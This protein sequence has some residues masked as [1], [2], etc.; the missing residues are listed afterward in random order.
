LVSRPA[1]QQECGAALFMFFVWVE[2]FETAI[3]KSL[4]LAQGLKSIFEN[5]VMKSTIF[6]LLFVFSAIIGKAQNSNAVFFTEQGERFSVVLNGV[7][8]NLEPATNIKLVDLHAPNYRLKIIFENR[9][10]G[11]FDRNLFLEPFAENTFIIR[12][13]NRGEWIMRLQSVTPLAQIVNFNSIPQQ[14]IITYHSTPFPN[15]PAFFP[16][17]TTTTTTTI[18]QDPFWDDNLNVNFGLNGVGFNLNV[19]TFDPFWPGTTTQTTQTTTFINPQPGFQQPNVIYTQPN[20]FPTQPNVI[21]TQPNAFPN[22]TV[23]VN[24]PVP[25]NNTF[26]M[27][28]YNG[29]VGCPMPMSQMDFMNARNSISNVSFESTKLQIARQVLTNNCMTAQQ[30]SD[31]MRLFSFESSRLEFAKFAYAYT[32]DIG[33]YYMVNNAFSFESSINDLN[34]FISG[35]RR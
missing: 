22:Q 34:R 11:E 14:S 16:G 33:N 29:P 19:N 27:P 4:I 17:Q 35:G 1:I 3:E 26:V 8:Q 2:L 12:R 21:Y 25:V 23:V 24:N 31:I 6:T 13:N 32:Y 15:Q 10:L 28:G 5:R 30:V 9:F 20:V 18:V 7:L